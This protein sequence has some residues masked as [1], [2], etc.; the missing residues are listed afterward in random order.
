MISITVQLHSAIDHRRDRLLAVALLANDDT[1]TPGRGNYT[2]A[3]AHQNRGAVAMGEFLE[4]GGDQHCWKRGRV[5][6]YRRAAS[7]WYLIGMMLKAARL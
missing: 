1:G 2:Y 5:T 3:I 4:S 6:G 7:V